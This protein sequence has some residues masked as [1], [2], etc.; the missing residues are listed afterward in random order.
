MLYLWKRQNFFAN[1]LKGK[2]IFQKFNTL[3]Q[4]IQKINLDIKI[5]EKVNIIFSPSAA[6]F[7]QFLNF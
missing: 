7:D 5:Q 4:V 2:I 6:S 3:N 1:I